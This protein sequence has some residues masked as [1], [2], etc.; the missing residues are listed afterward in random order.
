MDSYAPLLERTRVPQPSLQ[1]LAV[2]SIFSKLRSSPSDFEAISS[3]LLSTSPAVVDQSVRELC[4]LVS[5]SRLEIGRG[6]LELQSAFEGSD[7][8]FVNV[9]VKGIGFM[10]R[11]GFK[12]NLDEWRECSPETHPFIKILSCRREAQAELRQQ[13]MLILSQHESFGM[14]EDLADFTCIAQCIVDA[15]VVA[16]RAASSELLITKAQLCG[17]ELVETILSRCTELGNYSTTSDFVLLASRI[18]TIQKESGL[19][20]LPQLSTVLLALSVILTKSELEHEQVPIVKL[21]ILL[22]NW[23]NENDRMVG[24]PAAKVSEG[25]LCIFPVIKL[26]SSPSKYVKGAASELLM[27]LKNHLMLLLGASRKEFT[28]SETEFPSI[29]SPEVIVFRL[30][31]NVWHQD[32][33]VSQNFFLNLVTSA[34]VNNEMHFGNQSW[35]CNLGHF[36][37][38]TAEQRKSSFHLKYQEVFSGEMSLLVGAVASVLILHDSLKREAVDTLSAVGALDSKLGVTILLAILFYINLFSKSETSNDMQVKLLGLLPSLASHSAMIPLIVQTILPFLA[39]DKNSVLYATAT[40][41]LCK[42]WEYNDRAFGSLQR[43]LQPIKFADFT[44]DRNISI[45]MAA[46]MRDVCKKNPDRGVDLILSVSAC[47]ES[48]DPAV[49]ALGLEC[50]SQLCEADV[51]DLYTAWDVIRNH[52]AVTKLDPMVARSLCLLLRWGAMDAEAHPEASECILKIIWDIGS[53]GHPVDCNLWAE[54]RPTA[55][56]ALAHFEVPQLDRSIPEFRAKLTELLSSTSDC[57]LLGAIEK[58]M[59]KLIL[60]EN[61][62]R[63]R[64]V[65]EKKVLG[66]KVEKLLD[67]FPKT[68]FPSG[69]YRNVRG[70]PGAALFSYSLYPKDKSDF[71]PKELKDAHAGYENTLTESAASLHL[72]R[73][74]FVALLT[75]KS[76]EPFMKRWIKENVLSMTKRTSKVSDTTLKAANDILQSLTRIAENAIPRTGENIALAIG[77]FCAILP[78]SVHAVKA[79]STQFLLTWLSS[80]E[81]EYRQWS[82]ALSLGV[83]SRCLHITDHKLKLQIINGLIEVACNSKSTLVKGACGVGL[84]LSCKSLLI[85]A[86]DVEESGLNNGTMWRQELDIVENMVKAL[87]QMTFQLTQSSS[88]ILR[89]ICAFPLGTDDEDLESDPDSDLGIPAVM[90]DEIWGVAGLV[91]G[92][93]NSVGAVY[94]AGSQDLVVKIKSMLISWISYPELQGSDPGSC[95]ERCEI[96]LS[97]G[98]CLA[99]PVVV[100]FCV[101]VELIDND[102]LEHLIHCYK[103]RIS[104]LLLCKDPDNFHQSLL[105]ASCVGAGNLLACILNEGVHSIDVKE[106]NELLQLYKRCYSNP[107]PLIN[108]GGMFGAVNALGA[109]ADIYLEN[110]DPIS[111]ELTRHESKESLSVMGPLVRSSICEP[112]VTLLIQEMFVAAQNSEDVQLQQYAAWA[113]SFLRHH[114]FSDANKSSIESSKSSPSVPEDSVVMKLSL[115]LMHLNY[116]EEGSVTHPTTVATVIRCLSLAPR[117]PT[118]DWGAI[119]RRCMRYELQVAESPALIDH[120]K[121]NVRE[122]CLEFSLVHANKVDLLQRFLDELTDLS[123]FESLELNLQSFILQHISDMIKVFSGSRLQKLFNDLITYFSFSTSFK[124]YSLWQK[125]LLRKSIWKGIYECLVEALTDASEHMAYFEKCMKLLFLLLPQ[126]KA[127]VNIEKDVYIIEEWREAVQCLEKAS[128]DWLLNILQIHQQ[129]KQ[130]ED[131]QEVKKLQVKA[132]L[133]GRGSLALSELG[134][135][136]TLVLDSKSFGEFFGIIVFGVKLKVCHPVLRVNPIRLTHKTF[137]AII[138]YM[139]LCGVVA[140]SDQFISFCGLAGAWDVLI[141]FVAALQQADSSSKREWLLD[142]VQMSSI[143]RYPSMEFWG[144]TGTSRA[145]FIKKRVLQFTGLIAGSFCKYM[146]LLIL[147]RL[148]VLSDLPVTLRSLLTDPKWE[149]MAESVATHL[150]TAAERIY[151]WRTCLSQSSTLPGSCN[152]DSSEDVMADFLVQVLYHTCVSLRH[153]LPLDKQLRLTNMVV[154]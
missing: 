3:C 146:P 19:K 47:I 141:E 1:R 121:P 86:I 84:G 113:L 90:K 29:S 10:V 5:E 124:K 109:L 81:H 139:L 56:E 46:C 79:K 80:N 73:N 154:S 66:N 9:F 43:C 42:T 11:L 131:V 112:T 108:L 34:T 145:D 94:R 142:V 22:L 13:V 32:I 68:I 37:L 152:I 77:A 120:I 70:L 110:P 128:R 26:L 133:V 18:I 140:T 48:H 83:V 89:S 38:W 25:L 138:K 30:L 31:Q 127:D 35:T 149:P 95:S 7:S 88:D 44:Y 114:L 16:V 117:L 143:S 103:D 69:N 151:K 2:I 39:G 59:G 54:T 74:I 106:I 67:V 115:W 96:M 8:R 57:A 132:K 125:S 107:F 49:K 134:R 50:L 51:I 92:L 148:T 78:P 55:V 27:V 63:R 111:S 102:E 76:W 119:M 17:V 137:W 12:E 62:N 153:Y 61:K 23:N 99:L 135:L 28:K 97:V 101:R 58:L 122:S 72:S 126:L 150:F 98:S 6:L 93:G 100:A 123:R 64:L 36:P 53:Y 45:S 24:Q 136:K 15:H 105:M 60:Y 52:V 130:S 14:R 87:C 147:D 40:R 21:L 91:M 65:K 33:F 82:A 118:L 20:F 144:E 104:T 116:S 75:L 71:I 4:R 85:Q 41:L 129:E